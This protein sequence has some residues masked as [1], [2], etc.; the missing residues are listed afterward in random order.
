MKENNRLSLQSRPNIRTLL[1][2]RQ[3]PHMGRGV[4]QRH[5]KLLF[6]RGKYSELS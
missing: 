1:S 2:H 4:S 5:N 6:W 3:Q